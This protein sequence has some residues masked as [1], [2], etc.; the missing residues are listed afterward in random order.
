MDP[1][2][3]LI[4]IGVGL[5]V[6]LL[7]GLVGIGGGVLIVPFLYFFYDH[8]DLFGVLVQPESRTV[9]AHGTSLF[10][11]MPTSVRGALAYHRVGLVEW[12][13]VW[14]IGAASVAAAVLGARL[15]TALPPE[16]LKMLFGVLLVFSGARGTASTAGAAPFA[17]GDRGD[18][19]LGGALLRA[20]RRR[21]RDHRH[22]AADPPDAPGGAQ[23]GRDLHR[24]HRHHR[25][26]R[27]GVLHVE[28]PG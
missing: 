17:S 20:A 25:R 15:A 1:F 27:S 23:G 26:R 6:G 9:L 4:I 3:I 13:A 18:G 28:R 11:I 8:P 12:R 2:T 10:A 21:R 7:S 24:D 14:P 5:V 16:L 19:A 22:S